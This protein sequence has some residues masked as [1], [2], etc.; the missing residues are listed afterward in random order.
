MDFGKLIDKGRKK[1]RIMGMKKY[2]RFL[3]LISLVSI[4]C[5]KRQTKG[6]TMPLIVDTVRVFYLGNLFTDFSKN[7]EI[8]SRIS[9]LPK[10]NSLLIGLLKPDSGMTGEVLNRLGFADLLDRHFS[11]V[12]IAKGDFLTD[13]VTQAG[14]TLLDPEA[15]Y[16]IKN[17]RFGSIGL[18]T[19]PDSFASDSLYFRYRK[20]LSLT[21]TR[22][23]FV[24]TVSCTP[25][26]LSDSTATL[27]LLGRPQL[28][29]LEVTDRRVKASFTRDFDSLEFSR[30]P[31]IEQEV[32]AFQQ[33]LASFRN[34]VLFDFSKNKLAKIEQFRRRFVDLLRGF[35]NA[36]VVIIP[37]NAFR[38]RSGLP[39][40]IFTVDSLVKYVESDL[41]FN[42]HKTTDKD[43]KD[44]E[45]SKEY[46]VYGKLK[47]EGEAVVPSTDGKQLFDIV[48][49]SILWR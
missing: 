7:S 9:S 18:I 48:Y 20:N 40:G 11:G 32:A 6:V 36:G 38:V 39:A 34:L 37:R 12:L 15:G 21:K 31:A 22:S 4:A 35:Y 43:I 25:S 3:I 24:I 5:P 28:V 27:D 29:G 17:Y 44:F 16:L 47:K 49:R 14:Y 2:L 13:G 23:D 41:R 8:F 46:L 33:R 1:D 26:V 30:D 42:V 10:E 45:K 19:V